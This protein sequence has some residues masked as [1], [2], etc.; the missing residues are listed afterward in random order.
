MHENPIIFGQCK[1]P[2]RNICLREPGEQSIYFR[3]PMEYFVEKKNSPTLNGLKV[4]D[5]EHV[6]R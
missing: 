3:V 6:C 2:L 1:I 4:M 5:I